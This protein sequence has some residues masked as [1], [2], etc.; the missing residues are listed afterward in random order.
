MIEEALQIDLFLGS[1]EHSVQISKY[2]PMA[3]SYDQVGLLI[4]FILKHIS[5]KR[6]DPLL[7]NR[8]EN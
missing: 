5:N 2:H 1:T 6:R 7:I 4:Y 8:L 3:I